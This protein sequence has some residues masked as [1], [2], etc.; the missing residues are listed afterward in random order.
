MKC[1]GLDDGLLLGRRVAPQ[2]GSEAREELVHAERLGD[3][4][5]GAGV[6]GRD[7][8][9]LGFADG[10]DDDRHGGPAAQAADH[11]DAVDSGEA[12]V[13]DDE[14]GVLPGGDRERRLA[15]L[16]EVDVVAAC[17][18]VGRERAQDLGLVVD[19]EDA[20][21]S[22]ARSR[23]TMVSPPPGVSSAS[24][25]PPIAST[26]PF[27]TARPSPTP[28]LWP[29]SPSRWKGLNSRSRSARG[30]PGP[31]VDDAHVDDAV[32]DAGG[33]ARRRAGRREAD[34]VRDHVGERALE[35]AAIGE[36]ARERL[37]DVE[38]DRAVGDADAVQRGGKH[39]VEA[40]RHGADLERARLEPA[41]VEQV[42]DERVEAVGLL[43]DRLE[44]LLPRL[45]RPVDVALEQ[46]RDRGLDRGDRRAQV[47]RDGGEER[48]AELVRRRER[49]CRLG[50]GLELAEVDGGGELLGEGV[51]HALVLAADRRAG[52][53]EH[54][55]GV[56]LDRRACSPRGSRERGLRSPPRSASR[57][58]GGGEPP[59]PRAR[60]RGRGPR[61]RADD[62]RGAGEP[63]ERLGLGAGAGSFGRAAG[64]ERDEARDDRADGEEDEEREHVL[65]VGDRERVVGLD[66]E[67]VDEQEAADR[68]R[69]AGPEPADGGDRDDEEQE[70]EHH[71]RQLELVAELGEEQRQE[72][73]ARRRRAARRAP[74]VGAGAPPGGACGERRTPP[75]SVPRGG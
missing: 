11:F 53:R 10:E 22:A 74:G 50:L 45:G 7:L 57:L 56:E 32:D 28:S 30:T 75:P 20:R 41:H 26:K 55:L 3:V 17:A 29:E 60:A 1:V 8:V 40:D 19:D 21:H 13:E 31:A 27:A 72:R 35:Q 47:V 12:E 73:A 68:G 36:H 66:E 42:A 69:Q 15:G 14:V 70:E 4:V 46:A 62:R 39:L 23:A 54:V 43:V 16:G 18:E 64:G 59:L 25:S 48:R 33:H 67:P 24:I 6:E 63:R 44:E 34:R 52:E 2:R 9:A 51:E 37:G 61:A 38:L 5:V 65:G 71:A 49:A 58:R